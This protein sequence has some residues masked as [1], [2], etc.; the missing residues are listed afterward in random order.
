M[1]QLYS[2]ENQIN[3]LLQKK[4]LNK[5]KHKRNTGISLIRMSKILQFNSTQLSE[6]AELGDSRQ[7]HNQSSVQTNF[8]KIK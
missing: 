8:S 5:R 4:T 3:K 1:R 2:F 6:A 7:S